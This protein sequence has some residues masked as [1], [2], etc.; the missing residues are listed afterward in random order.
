MQQKM[1]LLDT[2]VLFWWTE[3]RNLQPALRERIEL[4][5]RSGSLFLS[6][7]TAWEI[8]ILVGKG[9]YA[10]P[11]SPLEWWTLLVTKG[12]AI[13]V[14]IDGEIALRSWSLPGTIHNDP[15]DRLILATALLKGMTLVTRDQKLID[16]ARLHAVDIL[17]A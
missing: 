8:G 7:A 10:L 5:R 2:H 9:Q 6:A 17:P 4:A 16:Y 14:P 3:D 1:L 13:Q 15:A 12:G 11:R